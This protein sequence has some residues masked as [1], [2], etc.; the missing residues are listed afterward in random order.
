[1]KTKLKEA[2][3]DQDPIITSCTHW[4]C[5]DNMK[6]NIASQGGEDFGKFRVPLHPNSDFPP[7]ET[8]NSN[9]YQSSSS[10]VYGKTA[11]L[12]IKTFLI[13]AL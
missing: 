3:E 9:N 11:K 8:N 7:T 12:E 5:S 1:M 4:D 2:F 13:C 6:K 10:L